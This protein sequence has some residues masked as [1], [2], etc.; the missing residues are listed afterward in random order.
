MLASVWHIAFFAVAAC[1]RANFPMQLEWLEGG[2]LDTVGRVL[3][4]QPIYVAPTHLFVPYIYTPFYYYAGALLCHFTGLGFAPLRWLSTASTA[5]CF[6]LIFQQTRE[7]TGSWRAGLIAV[8]CFAG[9]YGA[10]GAS[11]DLARVD[12]LFL[13]FTLAAIYAA[14]RDRSWLAGLLFACAYQSKQ[15]AAI[16]AICVLAAAWRRP[17]QWLTGTVTFL[18]ATLVSALLMNLL[19]SGWYRFYTQWLP[20]HHA[21]YPRGVY[22]LLVRDLGR[23]LLP[24]L[25]LIAL[26]ALRR[27]PLLWRSR[28]G[29]FLLF[30][31]F[32]CSLAAL[33]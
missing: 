17:R 10:S 11:Y 33:A 27:L 12:M 9:L 29:S 31:T 32:G 28:R 2:V 7:F 14:W 23:Y 15:G 8:G 18:V 16:I 24:G 21:L 26:S 13:V 4:H 30:C 5:G 3:A 22:Y 1:L 20:A 25:L 6:A 19:S